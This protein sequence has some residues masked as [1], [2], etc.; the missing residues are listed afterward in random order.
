[1]APISS[2]QDSSSTLDPE[3]TARSTTTQEAKRFILHWS[4]RAEKCS[5]KYAS[6]FPQSRDVDD[7]KR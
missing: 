5:F 7:R 3:E 4:L 1:M 6:N 2:H